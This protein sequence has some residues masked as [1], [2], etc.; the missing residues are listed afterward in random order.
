MGTNHMT[1]NQRGRARVRLLALWFGV[2]LA[3]IGPLTATPGHA[4][5]VPVFKHKPVLNSLGRTMGLV[6]KSRL[7]QARALARKMKDPL[8][9]KLVGWLI[10]QSPSSGAGHEQINRFLNANPSWPRGMVL[11]ARAEG[12]QLS[13]TGKPHAVIGFFKGPA[14]QDRRRHGRPRPLAS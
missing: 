13:R 10:L 9:E 8:A 14:S 4:A 12:A 7:T 1:E 6:R 5:M 3:M 2:C 11:K